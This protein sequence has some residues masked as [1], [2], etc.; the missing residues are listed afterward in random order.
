MP[1]KKPLVQ[2]LTPLSGPGPCSPER[3]THDAHSPPSTGRRARGQPLLPSTCSSP[4]L[5]A[6][7]VHQ[8][9]GDRRE[10]VTGE[11]QCSPGPTASRYPV[12][13]THLTLP[14][15]YSV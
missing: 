14:T 3:R 2:C 6:L 9:Y 11:T 5:I 12:S 4:R 13:Y 8:A 7:R 10:K 1:E 15:I